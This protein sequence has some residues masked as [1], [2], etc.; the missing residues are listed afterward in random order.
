ME[1]LPEI[2]AT[3]YTVSYT[4]PFQGT[5][6]RERVDNNNLWLDNTFK[7]PLYA[8][9]E[10]PVLK[11]NHGED[12]EGFVHTLYKHLYSSPRYHETVEKVIQKN[13]KLKPSF[14]AFFTMLRKE[15]IL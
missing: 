12:C 9:L 13:P 1:K 3:R 10:N 2:A 8:T 14:D 5:R 6:L 11:T 4:Y 15:K 7:D